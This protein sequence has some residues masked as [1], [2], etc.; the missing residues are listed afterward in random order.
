MWLI[1]IDDR[2]YNMEEKKEKQNLKKSKKKKRIIFLVVF[3]LIVGAVLFFVFSGGLD[4]PEEPDVAVDNLKSAGYENAER[5]P[6]EWFTEL[7]VGGL[8][9]RVSA[10]RL[11]PD[12]EWIEIYYFKNDEYADEAWDAIQKHAYSD[13]QDPDSHGSDFVCKKSGSVIWFGTENAVDA[14]NGN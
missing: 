1:A 5:I 6:G 10:S 7:R 11:D 12:S 14:A 13:F 8:V 3:A 4:V 2:I 9:C